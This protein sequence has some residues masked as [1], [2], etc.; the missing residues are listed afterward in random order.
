MVYIGGVQGHRPTSASTIRSAG[1]NT[2][3][4][5]AQRGI[6]ECRIKPAEWTEDRSRSSSNA[7]AHRS[8]QRVN[9]IKQ[10]CIWTFAP[11]LGP[12]GQLLRDPANHSAPC[13]LQRPHW[14][15]PLSLI[16]AA[17]PAGC[18]WRWRWSPGLGDLLMAAGII[19][20]RGLDR[21]LGLGCGLPTLEKTGDV[22]CP[23]LCQSARA[24]GDGASSLSPVVHQGDSGT[25]LNAECSVYVSLAPWPPFPDS[26][27]VV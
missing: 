25:V 22:Q 5:G 7:T 27:P 23:I 12:V 9:G 4:E 8:S 14:A 15:D 21:A 11:R 19:G 17:A 6:L 1:Q 13:H 10:F 3:H 18:D 16:S 20:L 26:Q 2:Q 24:P